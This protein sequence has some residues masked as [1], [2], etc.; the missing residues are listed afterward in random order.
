[1]LRGTK[2]AICR[3]DHPRD[4]VG[5]YKAFRWRLRTAKRSFLSNIHLSRSIRV[6][7]P[8]VGLFH[9]VCFRKASVKTKCTRETN[10]GVVMVLLQIVYRARVSSSEPKGG[11][12]MEMSPAPTVC[13][14]NVRTYATASTIRYLSIIQLKGCN[15]TTIV[16]SSGV[17]FATFTKAA[18]VEDVNNRQL[19]NDQANGRSNGCPRDIRVQRGLFRA[20]NDSVRFQ[21]EDPRVNVSFVNAS[22]SVANEN[23][24]GIHTHRNYFHVRRGITRILTNDIH[25]MDQIRISF[26]HARFLFG[27]FTRL[28]TFSVGNKRSSITQF[29]VRRLGSAFT[30]VKFRSIGTTLRWGKIRSTFFNG[31]ELTLSG[32]ARVVFIRG[33]MSGNAVFVNVFHPVGSYSIN[34]NVLLGFRWG[35]FRITIK[36]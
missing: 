8:F 24:N 16:R 29:G 25:R 23:R 31:R 13:Q 36:V 19:S 11:M 28:L 12:N 32:V 30:R 10:K 7:A 17:M 4:H 20:R 6:L 33:L 15:A 14:A 35:F 5:R 22:R 2:R 18:M 34:D 26:L 1:M 3:Q 27:G 21:R 9:R